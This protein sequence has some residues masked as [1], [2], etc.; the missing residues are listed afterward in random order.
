M[1]QRQDRLALLL[2]LLNAL[3]IVGAMLCSLLWEPPASDKTWVP[4][5]PFPNLALAPFR[6]PVKPHTGQPITSW[7]GLVHAAGD[8]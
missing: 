8:V 6:E 1:E 7:A 4:A 2:A 3:L 5:S